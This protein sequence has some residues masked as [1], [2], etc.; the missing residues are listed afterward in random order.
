MGPAGM[1]GGGPHPSTRLPSPPLKKTINCHRY[2]VLK[3]DS[4]KMDRSG[5]KAGG[6]D[7]DRRMLLWWDCGYGY[8]YGQLESG[9]VSPFAALTHPPTKGIRL[10]KSLS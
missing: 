7:G 9:E 6:S 4:F 5:R 3:V 2:V 8:E 10:S 1:G